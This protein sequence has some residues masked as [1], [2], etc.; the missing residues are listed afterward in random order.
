MVKMSAL[1]PP[2]HP[3]EY[4]ILCATSH[5]YQI[6]YVD[7]M[8]HS[9]IVPNNHERGLKEVALNINS[10]R[11]EALRVISGFSLDEIPPEW[12]AFTH[13]ISIHINGHN[14]PPLPLSFQNFTRLE[15]A[16]FENIDLQ[17]FFPFFK[18][19]A[20]LEY[21]T[22]QCCS[23]TDFSLPPKSWRRVED[24]D[25][26][27]NSI[28][29][30]PKWMVHQKSIR[31]VDVSDNKIQDL[32]ALSHTPR[33]RWV[34]LAISKNPIQN[35]DPLA[36]V[37][38]LY[39]LECEE[40]RLYQLPTSFFKLN[41]LKTLCLQRNCLGS[42]PD[43]QKGVWEKL[44][45]I[46]LGFNRFSE[47][48]SL[49]F[50]LPTVKGV[51]LTGNSFTQDLEAFL[52]N[53]NCWTPNRLVFP[54]PEEF[55]YEITEQVSEIDEVIDYLTITATSLFNRIFEKV[56]HNTPLSKAEKHHPG[57]LKIY[58]LLEEKCLDIHNA[59]TRELDE[60]R[61]VRA[62]FEKNGAKIIL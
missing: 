2:L 24:I 42:L 3:L 28:A 31:Y 36:N 11:I 56:L 34:W 50:Q 30:I 4:E 38:R 5:R 22:A 32:E 53:T 13:L 18:Q 44:E 62:S 59:T 52:K 9:P 6:S 8:D 41:R 39:Q 35:Y 10:G 12:G 55:V 15:S 58:P 29:E 20:P 47:V 48:P 45:A 23:L 27:H 26:S 46:D 40:N 7:I 16:N 33:P 57:F 61:W 37:Y 51:D 54:P 60:T 21:F 49:P 1:R 25:L 17:E 14:L 43:Y 19:W